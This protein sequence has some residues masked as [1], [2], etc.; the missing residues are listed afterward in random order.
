MGGYQ[1]C[2]LN[3]TIEIVRKRIDEQF[4]LLKTEE[5]KDA[6]AAIG[7]HVDGVIRKLLV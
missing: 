2:D 1:R 4:D 6:I 7:D 3:N 5:G